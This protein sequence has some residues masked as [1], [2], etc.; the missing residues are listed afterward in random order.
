M[1]RRLNSWSLQSSSVLGSRCGCTIGLRFGRIVAA[2]PSVGCG[3]RITALSLCLNE[4]ANGTVLWPGTLCC[5]GAVWYRWLGV[6]TPVASHRVRWTLGSLQFGYSPQTEWTLFFG[7]PLTQ[8]RGS[9]KPWSALR[10]LYCAGDGQLLRTTG[11]RSWV[12]VRETSSG[13]PK[14]KDRPWAEVPEWSSAAG[15]G[16]FL[17]ADAC[18]LE[19]FTQCG[20]LEHGSSPWPPSP[21][22]PHNFAEYA[23]T[24]DI[25]STVRVWEHSGEPKPSHSWYGGMEVEREFRMPERWYAEG[26]VYCPSFQLICTP[27][28]QCDW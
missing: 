28:R 9:L 27:V 18:A 15:S 14:R 24:F 17:S 25:G 16:H 8:R 3:Y 1:L 20:G 19:Q 23:Q 12:G 22:W 4:T 7:V 6:D 5:C 10:R 26:T 21:H 13:H 11:S 2:L